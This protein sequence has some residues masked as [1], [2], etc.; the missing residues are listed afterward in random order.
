MPHSMGIK[1]ACVLEYAGLAKRKKRVEPN[2]ARSNESL[3]VRNPHNTTP[4]GT[5]RPKGIPEP[6]R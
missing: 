2:P 4:L 5:A 1:R 6:F 3:C